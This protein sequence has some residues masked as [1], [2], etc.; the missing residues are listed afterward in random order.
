MRQEARDL[1]TIGRR[2]AADAD[3]A[4]VALGASDGH[5]QHLQHARIAFV[6]IERDDLRV[7][8]GAQ[9]QLRQII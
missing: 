1:R 9:R 8:I 3:V 7:A 5:A 2:L 6:E 4:V